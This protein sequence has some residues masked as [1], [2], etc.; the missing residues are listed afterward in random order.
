MSLNST[1]PQ[2][3]QKD[4]TGIAETPRWDFNQYLTLMERYVG[5]DGRVRALNPEVYCRDIS[6]VVKRVECSEWV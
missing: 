4:T 3:K 6:G 2:I 5:H 1:G